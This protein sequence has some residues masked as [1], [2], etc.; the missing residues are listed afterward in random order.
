V[1]KELVRIAG[2]NYYSSSSVSRDFSHCKQNS[3]SW[4]DKAFS[5]M[6]RSAGLTASTKSSELMK[7]NLAHIFVFE[8]GSEFGSKGNSI[9]M[10]LQQYF[11][12][13]VI[14]SLIPSYG[15]LVTWFCPK[16]ATGLLKDVHHATDCWRLSPTTI[17]ES[18][19]AQSAISISTEI[20]DQ[21]SLLL[22]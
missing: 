9:H 8:G 20:V 14:P 2:H 22:L 4:Y 19:S 5:L 12:K 18:N 13:K 7:T 11:I 15:L 6:M 17:F 10:K 21:G 16:T 1:E 3:Q